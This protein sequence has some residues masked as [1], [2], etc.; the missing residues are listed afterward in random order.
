[1]G[2]ISGPKFL[3]GCTR[4]VC[5]WSPLEIEH[6]KV[7]LEIRPPDSGQRPAGVPG[8]SIRSMAISGK[9]IREMLLSRLIQK[10]LKRRAPLS[11]A[12]LSRYLIGP[13]PEAAQGV[14][15]E[16]TADRDVGCIATARDQDPA[17]ARSVIARVECVPAA[18]KEYLEPSR[19]IPDAV[20]RWH[21][22][23][24][25]VA[26]TVTRRDVH[27]AAER[28]RQVIEIA[29]YADPVIKGFQCGP[30]IFRVLIAKRDV[31]V[32]IIANCLD[33][34]PPCRTLPEKIPR[35]VG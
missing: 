6:R 17:D 32:D 23:V 26:G 24:A 35:N 19:E 18:A 5:D 12:C 28:Y 16:C 11:T 22:D 30:R 34:A 7:A 3:A 2:A 29:T 4:P 10:I 20:G 14:G 33:A 9:N 27:T 13:N 15:S 31:P 8:Q 21:S 1:M 25:Q